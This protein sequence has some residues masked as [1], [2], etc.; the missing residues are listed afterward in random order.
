MIP[1]IFPKTATT[2][3]SQGAGPLTDALS[4][5]VTEERNGAFELEL[6]YPV[7]GLHAD[8]LAINNIIVAHASPAY[9]RQAFDIYEIT[10]EMPMTLHVR[11]RHISYRLSY[12]PVM[13][14]SAQDTYNAL[15]EMKQHSAEDNPFT[16]DVRGGSVSAP[17]NQTIPASFRS[18]LAGV[19]GSIIDVYGGE[20]EFDNW[21]VIWR[22]NRGEDRG[23]VIRYGKNLID[24]KQEENFESVYNGVVPYWEDSET[25]TVVTCGVI[26]SGHD[27]EAPYNRTTVLDMSSEFQEQPT[28]AQLGSAAIDYVETHGIFVPKVSITVSF[29]TLDHDRYSRFERVYLCDTVHVIFDKFGITAKAKIIKTVYDNLLD[30]YDSVEVG[31]VRQTIDKTIEDLVEA[32]VKELKA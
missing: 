18:R 2:F 3:T 10:K 14:C 11:A 31:D 26:H 27:T 32:K 28:E 1:V 17:Y 12:I 30:R 15:W 22:K 13:P 4:C 8:M 9:E 7:N 16:F 23:F 20:F 24:L 19:R 21:D 25:G 6:D 29:A 5:L